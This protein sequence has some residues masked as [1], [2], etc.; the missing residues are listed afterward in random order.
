M[1]LTSGCGALVYS[2]AQLQGRE[3]GHGRKHRGLDDGSGKDGRQGYPNELMETDAMHYQ[4][5]N[6]GDSDGRRTSGRDDGRTISIRALRNA[7]CFWSAGERP[8]RNLL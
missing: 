7:W 6:I 1:W 3:S 5:T 8:Q 2:S 4:I